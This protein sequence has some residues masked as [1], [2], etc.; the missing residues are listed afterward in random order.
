[1]TMTLVS[2]VTTIAGAT[3]IAFSAIPQTGQDLLVVLNART[4]TAAAEDY[5]IM[6][7][8]STVTGYSGKWLYGTGSGTGTANQPYGLTTS[9][10]AGMAVGASATANT[11]SNNSLYI[12]NYSATAAKSLSVDSVG[13]NNATAAT[14]SVFA[15]GLTATAAVTSLTI[16]VQPSG[17]FVAGTTAS[18]YTI[19]T[20][21]ATGATV[22]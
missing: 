8:N 21:G 19:S 22:A 1:M 6:V 14:Q 3:S 17:A 10:H 11:F 9:W 5:L 13:E 2:T 15:G 18:L 4:T 16:T 20:T 7:V 12:P